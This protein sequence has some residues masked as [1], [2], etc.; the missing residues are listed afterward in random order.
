[1]ADVENHAVL[2]LIRKRVS[3]ESFEP[4]RVL[5]EEEIRALIQDAIEAPSSFNI[6]H[7]RFVAVRDPIDKAKLKEAAFGQQQVEDASVTF[8]ILGDIRGVEELPRVLDLAVDSGALPRGK[9]DAWL[10]TAEEIYGDPQMARD[11]AIRSCSLAAMTLMLAAE[12][13]GLATGALVGFDPLKVKNIFDIDERYL[14][15]MLLTVG[16]AAN[17]DESRKPRLT[18]DEV[19]SFDRARNF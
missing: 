9:A 17:T 14:P 2:E 10:R 12:A 1:M 4:D 7:W 19:L 6:Q 11:E 3:V 5:E 16:Y 15:V 18:V 8:I 13:R